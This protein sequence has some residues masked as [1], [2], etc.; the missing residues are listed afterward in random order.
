MNWL[1]N[2]WEKITISFL[3]KYALFWFIITF[4]YDFFYLSDISNAKIVH[5]IE[6]K[7]DLV[8]LPEYKLNFIFFE[9]FNSYKFY[10]INNKTIIENYCK[11]QQHLNMFN[12][13]SDKYLITDTPEL[14][15]RYLFN[16]TYF[17]FNNNFYSLIF[18]K[19]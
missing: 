3:I 14:F 7:I 6:F 1:Y 19:F 8:K 12:L 10:N 16:H 4:L 9:N 2:L 5:C 17:N 18:V 15:Y 13:R 11:I